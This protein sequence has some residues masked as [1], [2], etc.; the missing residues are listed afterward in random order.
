MA[1]ITKKT[2]ANVTNVVEL[3]W[4]TRY[5]LQQNIIFDCGTELMSEFA[6]MCRKDYVI[7]CCPI[8]TSKPQSNDIIERIIQTIGNIIRT[9]DVK[10]I[11]KDNPWSVILA[12]TM[13]GVCDKYHTTLIASPMQLVFGHN[14][15]LNSERITNWEHSRQ[16]KNVCIK[17]NNMRKNS[18]HT[19]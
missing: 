7:Q 14:T 13:F 6:K 10:K 3:T 9:F 11:D 1:A 15:I 4:F 19:A 17:K 5:I 16:Q 12:V 18:R 2:A 8:T